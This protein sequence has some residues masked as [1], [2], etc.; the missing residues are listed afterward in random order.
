MPKP[1]LRHASV[2]IHECLGLRIVHRPRRVGRKD[3][4]KVEG[5]PEA[6]GGA[7]TEGGTT[8]WKGRGKD[9]GQVEEG[10][11]GWVAGA[12]GTVA[13]F[14]CKNIGLSFGLKTHLKFPF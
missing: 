14:N 1:P 8:T 7:R 9:K 6:A 4:G 13:R 5:D 2:Q 3:K 12:G 10:T 11:V